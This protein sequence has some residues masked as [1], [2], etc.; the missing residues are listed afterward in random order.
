MK[1]DIEDYLKENHLSYNSAIRN[2]V[3][4]LLGIGD[5]IYKQNQSLNEQLEETRQ[6][7][8][9]SIKIAED[10]SALKKKYEARVEELQEQLANSESQHTITLEKL[11]FVTYKS[12]SE[13]NEAAY[14]YIAIH[15]DK[16]ISGIYT[17]YHRIDEHYPNSNI[18]TIFKTRNNK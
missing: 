18:Y 3:G 16:I 9:D 12:K 13:A 7:G 2:D 10:L 6:T 14:G 5:L 4:E 1:T 11:R 17:H 8:L 15:N